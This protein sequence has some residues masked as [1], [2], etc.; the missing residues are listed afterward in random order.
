M[1]NLFQQTTSNV[2]YS[3]VGS[4]FSNTYETN[5]LLNLCYYIKYYIT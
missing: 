5:E 3:M 1:L 4:L 2:H